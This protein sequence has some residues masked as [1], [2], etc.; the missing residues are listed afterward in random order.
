[1]G[2]AKTGALKRVPLFENKE[3]KN[4]FSSFLK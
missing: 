3:L 1:M 2:L 4:D